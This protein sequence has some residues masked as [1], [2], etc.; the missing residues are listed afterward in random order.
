MMRDTYGFDEQYLEKLRQG[1]IADYVIFLK[2][3]EEQR[4]SNIVAM[5]KRK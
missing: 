3:K 5:L 2:N 4:I 1:I